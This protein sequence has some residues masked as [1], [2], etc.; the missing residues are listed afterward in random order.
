VALLEVENLTK[1]FFGVAAVD[2]V[3]LEVNQG[4]IVGLIGPNGSGKTTLFNCVT[5]LLDSDG[6][7]VRF[8]DVDITRMKPYKVALMGI[9]RTFQTVR[10]FSDLT[11]REN[12]LV[13]IQQHQEDN[14][15][16]RLVRT[17][18]VRLF[19][20]NALSRADEALAV[21]GLDRH[22]NE[23]AANL[24]YGQRKLL[25]FAACLAFEPDIFLL[26]EPA[27]AVNPTMINRMK[28]QIRVL[29]ERGATFLIIEHNM[30]VIMDLS[31]R[32]IVFD[33]GKKIAEGEPS[34]I[35]TN[36]LVLEAYFGR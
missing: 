25:A 18:S 8:K 7:R 23:P 36:E 32:I 22:R 33:Y 6:G 11:V 16:G 35:Q 13:A 14:I 9:A 21:V 20:K 2:Q 5:R 30:E 34:A 29:N 24:S 28:E 12:L 1:R 4:E 17:N 3:D 27:S 10:V 31:H 26:D 19:E 15:L